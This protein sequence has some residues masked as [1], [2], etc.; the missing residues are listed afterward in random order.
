M[1]LKLANFQPVGLIKLT[2]KGVKSML[3]KRMLILYFIPFFLLGCASSSKMNNLRLGMTKAE[4][5]EVMGNPSST[6]EKD[7]TL[8]LKYRLLSDY[9]FKHDYYVRLTNGKVDAYGSAGQFNL[10]Y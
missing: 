9:L 10:G 3:L 7:D 4:V 2:Q 1:G 5:I 6:S 8:Y